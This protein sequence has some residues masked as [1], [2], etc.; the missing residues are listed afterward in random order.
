MTKHVSG[1]MKSH[2]RT[3]AYPSFKEAGFTAERRDPRS[4][5]KNGGMEYREG[6]KLRTQGG[7]KRT[8][9]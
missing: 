8:C 2:S 9:S 7:K 5:D 1:Q 4:R 3:A 6:G